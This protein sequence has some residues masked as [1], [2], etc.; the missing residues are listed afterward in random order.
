MGPVVYNCCRSSPAQTFTGQNPAGLMTPFC[1]LRLETT[2][3]WRARSPYLYHPGT[4]WPS[5]SPRHWVPFSSPP[6]TRRATMEVFDPD[7]TRESRFTLRLVVY[8]QSVR[9]D[10]KPLETHGH[11]FLFSNWTLS[12]ESLC[13]ILS[14]ENGSVVYNCCWASP[15]QSFSVPSSHSGDYEDLCLTGLWN[16]VFWWKLTEVSE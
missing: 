5:Y 4:G 6:T 2:P 14:N 11:N 9:L 8:R 15:A 12:I 3:T 13:N 16:H 1:C 7:S 10:A